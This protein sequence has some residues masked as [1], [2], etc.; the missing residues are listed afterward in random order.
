MPRK[1]QFLVFL[2]YILSVQSLRVG[3]PFL[4]VRIL[5][6]AQTVSRQYLV[7]DS[8]LLSTNGDDGKEEVELLESDPSYRNFK[9]N[10][11]PWRGTRTILTRRKQV[12]D[13]SYSPRK[14]VQTVVDALQVNDD[15]Q[16]D[17]GCCVLLEFT[18][19]DGPIA[20]GQLDPAQYGRFL[21]STDY[22]I[23][24]DHS[25]AEFIGEPV[26]LQSTGTQCKIKVKMRGW[27]G[28]EEFVGEM[29]EAFFD[30]Y[31]SKKGDYWLLD[32]VLMSSAD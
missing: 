18:N 30:F 12:P 6:F 20:E 26:D 29:Q 15:P 4:N 28:E 14:V 32:V 21:R 5:S 11:T 8:G 31:L 10:T 9:D 24:L 2:V 3:R 19:P 17:H 7:S 16:L 23:L 1:I 22:S 13:P 25:A 27:Y